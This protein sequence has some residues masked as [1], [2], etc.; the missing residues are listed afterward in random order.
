MIQTRSSISAEQA[1]RDV[2]AWM[3]GKQF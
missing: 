2:E 1:D 3:Q